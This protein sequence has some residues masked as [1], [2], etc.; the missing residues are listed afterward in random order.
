MP[1]QK[2]P[3]QKLER[4]IVDHLSTY[5]EENTLRGLIITL[6][7]GTRLSTYFSIENKYFDS[8]ISELKHTINKA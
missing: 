5:E 4:L 6:K 2:L 1:L 3:Y 8:F 7:N